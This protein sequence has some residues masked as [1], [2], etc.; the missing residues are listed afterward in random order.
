MFTAN[1]LQDRVVVITG[2]GS[3]L[4]Q[5]FATAFVEAGARVYISGRRQDTL[6]STVAALNTTRP[7]SA[8]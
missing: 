1:L 4:G 7:G 8:K 5:W 6:E 3:G 2:G